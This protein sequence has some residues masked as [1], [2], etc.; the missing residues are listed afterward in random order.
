[1][2]RAHAPRQNRE[3]IRLN[4]EYVSVLGYKPLF[5]FYKPQNYRWEIYF[6]L[7]KVYLVGFM[8]MFASSVVHKCGSLLC[9]TGRN[10]CGAQGVHLN[11]LGLFLRTS[12]LCIWSI[13]GACLPA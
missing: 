13:L 6:M 10:R 9:G 5:Q 3:S 11:R 12:T 2:K 7:Q 8:G 4:P 1:V